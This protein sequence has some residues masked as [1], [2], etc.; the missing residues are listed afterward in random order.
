MSNVNKPVLTLN[1]DEK[2]YLAVVKKDLDKLSFVYT[3]AC[4]KQNNTPNSYNAF[5]T[6]EIHTFKSKTYANVYY[7]TISQAVE[8]NENDKGRK[9]FFDTNAEIIESF[10][11]NTK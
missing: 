8:F 3:L 1:M 5:A 10:M 4:L 6:Q 9:I 11:E 7:E 2:I